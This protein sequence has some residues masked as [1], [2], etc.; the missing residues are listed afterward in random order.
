MD[1]LV[2]KNIWRRCLKSL[3]DT[4]EI[5]RTDTDRA[6][7]MRMFW[8]QS[9]SVVELT[10]IFS[11]T[12]RTLMFY[13][14]R[15]LFGN[16]FRPNCESPDELDVQ[17]LMTKLGISVSMIIVG[18]LVSSYVVYCK[19]FPLSAAF[20]MLLT[21]P[22]SW[23]AFSLNNLLGFCLLTFTMI[24]IMG[25]TGRCSDFR[26]GCICAGIAVFQEIC[27]CCGLTDAQAAASTYELCRS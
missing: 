27:G 24:P 16:M 23:L 26:N 4:S 22:H 15:H 9:Q 17:D 19:A 20:R 8:F 13:R 5:A 18:D 6:R 3:S 14:S 7:M 21:S 12:F 25:R 2:L 10:V 11:G 1:Q